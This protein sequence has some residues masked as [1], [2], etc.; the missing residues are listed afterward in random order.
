MSDQSLHALLAVYPDRSYADAAVTYLQQ[1]EKSHLIHVEGIAVVAKDL[2][3]KVTAEVVGGPSG[4]RGAARGAAIGAA[5]GLIFPPSVLGATIVGAGIGGLTGRL[6]G[7]SGHH[8][9]LQAMGERLERGFIGV[10]VLVGDAAVDQVAERL[11][12][13]EALHRQR[14]DPE[15]LVVL[16]DEDEAP[17]EG[18][19]PADG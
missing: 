17:A 14:V 7:R 12:G 9:A 4:K 5:V 15:T 6:R 16:A 10:I 8:A 13:C 11:T 2:V 19:A 18:G 3:G 1:M